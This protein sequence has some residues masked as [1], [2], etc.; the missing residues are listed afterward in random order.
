MS[1]IAIVG[2]GHVGAA[3]GRG[4]GARRAASSSRASAGTRQKR[5]E[6]A[7][8]FGCEPAASFEEAIGAPRGRGRAA[9]DAQR[10]ARGAG[11]RVRRARP[12]RVRREADRRQHRGGRADAARMRGRRRDADGRP[13]VP[14]ARGRP[15]RQAAARRGRARARGPRRGEHVAPGSFKPEAWRAHRERN[16][17]GPIMQLGIH[18]VDTLAYWLGPVQ[19]ASGRFAHVA[20]PGGHRRRRRRDARV[21]VR[22]ARPRSRAATCRRR[23]SRCGCSGRRRCSTTAPTSRSGRTR[24]RS[25]ARRLCTL[26]GEPVE[27]EERDMLAEELAEFGRCIRG[28][29]RAGDRRGRGH[30]DARRGASGARGARGGR[31]ADDERRCRLQ[32][33]ARLGARSAGEDERILR[34]RTRYLDD[35]EPPGAAHVAFVRSPFAHARIGGVGR[36]RAARGRVRGDHGGATWRAGWATCRCRASRAAGSRPRVTRCSPATRCATPASRWRRCWRSRARS[37][38]TP[39]SSSRSTTSRSTPCWTPAARTSR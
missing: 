35:I 24:R 5:A 21:R 28:D 4:R 6:F 33:A 19:R 27:F 15:A 30:R 37:P 36:P 17:G 16:P 3:P 8:R 34:G 38:R 20:H 39:P 31:G 26:A 12:P 11:A 32:S 22:R 23:R 14:P 10:R 9:R 13:C 7:E 1:G 25:T 29:A 18:H 2:H